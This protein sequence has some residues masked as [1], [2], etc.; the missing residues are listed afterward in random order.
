M[1]DELIVFFDA[2]EAHENGDC[3]DGCPWCRD[4]EVDHGG[5]G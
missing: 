1:R 2:H 3:E 5:E 4:E